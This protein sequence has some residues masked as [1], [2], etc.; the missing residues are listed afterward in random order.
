[1]YIPRSSWTSTPPKS[2]KGADNNFGLLNYRQ[3]RG[4]II[5][6]MN[7]SL[8]YFNDDPVPVLNKW[9]MEDYGLGGFGDISHNFAIPSNREGF[10]C[11]RGIISKSAANFTSE[12]NTDYLSVLCMVGNTEEPTDKL[13]ENLND[14]ITYIQAK[15]HSAVEIIPASEIK[16]GVTNSPGEALTAI[17]TEPD[18]FYRPSA[19]TGAIV[20]HLYLPPAPLPVGSLTVHV[21]DLIEALAFYGYYSSRNDG[22]YGPITQLA[23][24]NLQQDLADESIYPKAVDGFYGRWTRDCWST[25]L[26][27][28]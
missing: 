26:S 12:L 6:S 23:V 1:M 22:Q 28:M 2:N 9:K 20:K 16:P 19:T 10:Y 17:L 11:L 21:F 24:R 3:P 25:L 14:C 27:R 4:V 7:T 5:H 8:S 15:Y 18:V 13:L